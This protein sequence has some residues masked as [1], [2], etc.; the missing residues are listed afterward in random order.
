VREKEESISV[1]M[2]AKLARKKRH[3]AQ[4]LKLLGES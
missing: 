1:G 3:R 2:A 4:S